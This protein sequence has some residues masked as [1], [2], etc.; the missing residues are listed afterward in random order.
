[1]EIG[2]ASGETSALGPIDCGSDETGLSG[3]R[4]IARL[5]VAL[6]VPVVL[7]VG[8]IVILGPVKLVLLAIGVLEL[9]KLALVAIG[10]PEPAEL[11]VV[12]FASDLGRAGA[13]AATVSFFF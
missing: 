2:L 6:L 7:F 4:I 8:S 12:G 5:G 10:V 11:R 3:S 13:R 1:M 9:G